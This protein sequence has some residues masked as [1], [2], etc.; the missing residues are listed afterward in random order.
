[1][2]ESIELYGAMTGNSLRVAIALEEAALAYRVKVVDMRHG[3][4]LQPEFLRLNPLGKVPVII[5]RTES[6][7]ECVL[8]QS[9]AI[10]FYLADKAP[11]TLLPI[12]DL[13][14]RAV[15]LER[16]FYFL[17]DVIAPSHSGFFL[18]KQGEE[19]GAAALNQQA[20]LM[21]VSAER[22]LTASTFIAGDTF[23]VAD[24]AAFTIALSYERQIDWSALPLLK[25]WYERVR[26]RPAVIRGIVSLEA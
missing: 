17:T 4:H 25:A 1:M 8:T 24:I 23:T 20:L 5:E 15:A 9:N 18:R 19:A 7:A 14:L 11:G 6:G 10:I 12:H 21:L 13:R 26:T 16:F 22:F 3:E 2:N